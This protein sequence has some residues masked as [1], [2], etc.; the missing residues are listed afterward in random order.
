LI[1][2]VGD[3]VLRVGFIVGARVGLFVFVGF[4]NRVGGVKVGDLVGDHVSSLLVG[5]IVGVLV[6]F[7]GVFGLSV[8]DLV[9]REGDLVG[10]LVGRVKVGDFVGLFVLVVGEED[11]LRESP[12]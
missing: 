6:A 11:G 12:T 8:G 1:A 5:P 7:V 2:I 4:T 10:L 3:V 9:R